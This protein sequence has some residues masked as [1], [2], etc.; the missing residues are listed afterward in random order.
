MH[1]AIKSDID[2]NILKAMEAGRAG[3]NDFCIIRGGV[4]HPNLLSR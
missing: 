2:E 4:A 3:D 1:V